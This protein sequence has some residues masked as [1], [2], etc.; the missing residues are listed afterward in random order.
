MYGLKE[1]KDQRAYSFA[2]NTLIAS[3]IPHWNLAT[4]I[5][6]HRL[7]AANTLV[8]L[9]RV[10]EGYDLVFKQLNDALAGDNINDVI[11]NAQLIAILSDER[12]QIAYNLIKEKFKNESSVLDVINKLQ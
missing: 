11:Y 5:W 1:L 10:N 12:R 4:P 2:L 8:S 6:D 3:D 7:A 9:G